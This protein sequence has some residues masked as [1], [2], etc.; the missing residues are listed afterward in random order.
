MHSLFIY[1]I[2]FF[3]HP[4][5]KIPSFFPQIFHCVAPSLEGYAGKGWP[6]LTVRVHLI[7]ENEASLVFLDI[8]KPATWG[9][10]PV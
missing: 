10:R 9:R 4:L 8:E 7:A 3:Y 6:S 1:E 2:K 5:T